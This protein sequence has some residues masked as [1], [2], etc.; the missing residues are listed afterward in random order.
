MATELMTDTQSTSPCYLAD[1]N[2]YN[3]SSEIFILI[4][5]KNI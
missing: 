4:Y 3:F 2:I 5:S 1:I